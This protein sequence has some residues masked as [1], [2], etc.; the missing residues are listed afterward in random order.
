MRKL[1]VLALVASLALAAPAGAITFGQFDGNRHPNVGALFADYDPEHPG[2]ELL[3]TGTLISP[4]V[5]LTASHCTIGLDPDEFFVSFDPVASDED[6]GPVGTLLPATAV[7]H[8]DYAGH[9]KD[10]DIAV[11]ILD[12]AYTAAEP[13]ELPTLNFLNTINL[14]KQ[15]FT[16]VGYGTVREDKRKGPNA[17]FFDGTRRFATQSF[18]SIN[19]A[20]LTLNMNPSTGSGGTCYGDSGGPHFLG[21]TDLIVSITVTG[22]AV[23]RA[24]DKTFRVDTARARAFLSQFVTLP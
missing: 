20:W 23:C 9:M 5:V 8:P 1:L 14:R 10:P 17:F 21:N 22:D 7:T 2:V 3:C 11:V 15:R 6:G 18:L 13:A 4:T 16:A 12:E 19:R 24:T